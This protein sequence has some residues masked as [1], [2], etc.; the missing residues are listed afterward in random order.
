VCRF[1]QDSAGINQVNDQVA[2]EN[3]RNVVLTSSNCNWCR[4]KSNPAA[5][6]QVKD[7]TYFDSVR[8]HVLTAERAMLYA[9][10]FQFYIHHPYY[11]VLEVVN[12]LAKHED[13][14]VSAFWQRLLKEKL[15]VLLPDYPAISKGCAAIH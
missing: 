15:Q 3:V 8:E 2:C 13:P 7:R 11:T 6:E 10:G 14:E 4:Y 5:I 9:L 12:K 1:R